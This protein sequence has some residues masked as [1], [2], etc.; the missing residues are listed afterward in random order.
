LTIKCTAFM[1]LSTAISSPNSPAHRIGGWSE[2]WYFAG[3]DV[4]A[5]IGAFNYSNNPGPGWCPTR[6]AILPYGA[7]IV[8]QRF[9][10]VAPSV[11]QSQS[12]ATQFPGNGGEADSPQQALL[13]KAPSVGAPNI[14]RM[15][16]RAIPDV[17]ITEGEYTP[18]SYFQGAIQTHFS[19]LSQFQ[20]RGRDLTQPVY[21]IISISAA[22]A[23]ATEGAIT[24]TVGQ[25]VRVLKTVDSA[26]NLRGG[27]FQVATVGPLSTQFTLLN[28]PYSASAGGSVR[29]DAIVYP[30]VNANLVLPG[31]IITRRVGR[32]FIQFRG[33]RSRRRK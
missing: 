9:Q 25:M 6:A 23:V 21:K 13:C 11:G 3:T 7:A 8:G 17:N 24:F 27:R 26:G 12:T 14:R 29:A 2:S 28:W 32:P 30:A 1:Q 33:R 20:F 19:V 5:A 22:G 31:R 10:I 15:I 18:S 16:L 4:N